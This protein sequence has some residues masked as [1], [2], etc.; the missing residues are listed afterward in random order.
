MRLAD[1]SCDWSTS[2]GGSLA[3]WLRRRWRSIRITGSESGED[4][5]ERPPDHLRLTQM[6]MTPRAP[7]LWI[8]VFTLPGLA[9]VVAR[10]GSHPVTPSN[11]TQ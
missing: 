4:S 5:H 11:D 9:T 6:T 2:L 7:V 10:L 8:A 1:S 3:W